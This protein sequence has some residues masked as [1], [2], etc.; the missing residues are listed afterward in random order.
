MF[1]SKNL[2][3][4]EYNLKCGIIFIPL[5]HTLKYTLSVVFLFNWENCQAAILRFERGA[6]EFR[7]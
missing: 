5:Y 4:N 2:S 1:Q 6:G 3:L 7:R